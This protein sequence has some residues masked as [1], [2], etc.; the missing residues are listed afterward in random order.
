LIERKHKQ[1]LFKIKTQN[2]KF[3]N[4]ENDGYWELISSRRRRRERER[5]L[6]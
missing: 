3:G 2:K 1:R 4:F 6:K 5:K